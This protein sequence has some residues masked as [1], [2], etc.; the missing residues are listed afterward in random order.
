MIRTSIKLGN[1]LKYEYSGLSFNEVLRK[2]GLTKV[3][4]SNKRL[5]SRVKTNL[6]KNS[7]VDPI[8][9]LHTSD[10]LVK[11][12]IDSDFIYSRKP[13]N[14]RVPD[15]VDSTLSTK[16]NNL[17]CT[18]DVFKL[19][20]SIKQFIKILETL[21]TLKSK[22]KIE[23]YVLCKNKHYLRLVDK[24]S[25]RYLLKDIIK[26]CTILPD[27]SGKSNKEI[28]KYLFILGEYELNKNLLSHL[29]YYRVRLI[30]KFNLKYERKTSGFYKIQNNL[31]DYKKLMFLFI[32]IE[33]V[34]G[35]KNSIK[36]KSIINKA[37]LLAKPL[38]RPTILVKR[39]DSNQVSSYTKALANLKSNVNLRKSIKVRKTRIGIG[40][41]VEKRLRTNNFVSVVSK[42]KSGLV[43]S[44]KAKRCLR[45][46]KKER[47]GLFL[48]ITPRMK[49]NVLPNNKNSLHSRKEWVKR[50]VRK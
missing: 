39:I 50:T 35:K 32:L 45:L 5:N 6:I 37:K 20:K 41:E 18:L 34:L 14:K 12:L 43:L 27:L 42:R 13:I 22:Q 21:D 40:Y 28:T 30:S 29:I 17:V 1:A 9:D 4:Q 2:S 46:K 49:N 7:K 15:V 23:L 31:D 24:M 36:N 11:Q 44:K 33:K 26:V 25:R 19:N 48:P 3:T 10:L 47:E 16:E 8:K 38:A